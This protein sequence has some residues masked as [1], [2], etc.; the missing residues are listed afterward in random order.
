MYIPTY[1]KCKRVI[2]ELVGLD[3]EFRLLNEITLWQ[4]QTDL[5]NRPRIR[6]ELASAYI[7]YE[8]VILE[9]VNLNIIDLINL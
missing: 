1:I 7:R 8:R 4:R 2:C 3:I 9:L 6:S 5:N